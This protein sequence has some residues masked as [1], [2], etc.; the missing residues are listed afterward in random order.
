MLQACD[1]VVGMKTG[2]I[3]EMKAATYCV[4]IIDEYLNI[5]CMQSIYKE[6]LKMHTYTRTRTHTQAQLYMQLDT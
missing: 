6:S 4:K 1:S 2:D 5:W 3:M